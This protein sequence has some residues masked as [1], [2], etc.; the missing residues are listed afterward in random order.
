MYLISQVKVLPDLVGGIDLLLTLAHA[1][2][3]GGG[4]FGVLDVVE[5]VGDPCA[6]IIF[7]G[8]TGLT[9]LAI[10]PLFAHRVELI[11]VGI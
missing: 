2:H 4:D 9:D 3:R 11:E 6:E 10:E 8:P 5:T 1:L 7:L